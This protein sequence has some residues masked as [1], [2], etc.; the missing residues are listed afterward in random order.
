[1]SRAL[2]GHGRYMQATNLNTA[3]FRKD[4]P[5]LNAGTGACDCCW[6]EIVRMEDLYRKGPTMRTQGN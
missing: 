5:S 4:G 6:R 2:D 1:M 3:Q